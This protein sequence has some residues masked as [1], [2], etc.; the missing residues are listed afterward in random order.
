MKKCLIVLM[1]LIQSGFLFSQT[2]YFSCYGGNDTTGNGSNNSKYATFG[3]ALQDVPVINTSANVIIYAD[4]GSYSITPANISKLEQ[5]TFN[6]DCSL[7]ISG[8]KKTILTFQTLTQDTIERFKYYVNGSLISHSLKGKFLDGFFDLPIADNTENSIIVPTAI[9]DDIS[10]TVVELKT[11]FIFTQSTPVTVQPLVR[12]GMMY[13][14]NIRF[15]T[16]K[17]LKIGSI[18][19][20]GGLQFLGCS[21]KGQNI[22]L[23]NVR[24]E[25]SYFESTQNGLIVYNASVIGQ[26]VINFSGTGQYA[27]IYLRGG[28]IQMDKII[29]EGF[30]YA[31]NNDP[32][33]YNQIKINDMHSTLINT[34]MIKDCS[35]G[36][37]ID[38]NSFYETYRLSKILIDN[39]QYLYQTIGTSNIHVLFNV[40]QF[41]VNPGNWILNDNLLTD[42]NCKNY[43]NYIYGI[44]YIE[45]Q[46]TFIP[47]GFITYYNPTD[48]HVW[49]Y[50]DHWTKIK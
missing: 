45:S 42:D 6:G 28:Q 30:Y 2:I 26:S 49:M 36:F 11:K 48:K 8:C 27:G 38:D 16:S 7:R 29:I 17:Q 18:E 19:Q 24:T 35:I 31:V 25:P 22:Q 4:S 32:Y 15:E 43:L 13:F 47:T 40:N 14:E 21:F 44:N 23:T 34:I 39:V 10:K 20:Y 9:M 12:S 5:I 33:G 37:H 46:P 3:R 1:I 41:P 50:T